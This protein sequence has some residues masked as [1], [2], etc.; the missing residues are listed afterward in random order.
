MAESGIF[1]VEVS[2]R[3]RRSAGPVTEAPTWMSLLSML[4][5]A[6]TSM[7]GLVILPPL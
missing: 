6:R 7:V 4:R 2:L 5:R 1:G 3:R